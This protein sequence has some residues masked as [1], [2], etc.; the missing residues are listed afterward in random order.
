[1]QRWHQFIITALRPLCMSL[2]GL[3]KSR[4]KDNDWVISLWESA[5]DFP[6]PSLEGRE[7]VY[8]RMGTSRDPLTKIGSV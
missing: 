5:V 3:P 8:W 6:C 1:M 2:I 4:L 7:G